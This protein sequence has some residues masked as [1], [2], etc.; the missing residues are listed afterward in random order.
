MLQSSLH[1]CPLFL[2][3]VSTASRW[4]SQD[5]VLFNCCWP[6][7]AA[8]EAAQGPVP[9]PQGKAPGDFI[10]SPMPPG[11]CAEVVFFWRHGML[12]HAVCYQNMPKSSGSFLIFWNHSRAY[13]TWING[14]KR[15]QA[16]VSQRD[17]SKWRGLLHPLSVRFSC[18][19]QLDDFQHTCL[20]NAPVSSRHSLA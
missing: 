20:V 2:V 6:H 11:A 16:C 8:W 1:I 15:S 17:V 12:M 7:K 4:M 9:M 3:N 5:E 13:K 10:N 18:Y 19:Y 14:K